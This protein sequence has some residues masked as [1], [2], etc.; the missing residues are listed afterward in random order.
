MEMFAE[1]VSVMLPEVSQGPSIPH[2]GLFQA[3]VHRCSIGVLSGRTQY[4]EFLAFLCK[5]CLQWFPLSSGIS[6]CLLY[7]FSVFAL[8]NNSALYLVGNWTFF[9]SNFVILLEIIVFSWGYCLCVH[10]MDLLFLLELVYILELWGSVCSIYLECR[11]PWVLI[12]STAHLLLLWL[13]RQY[14]SLT[15]FG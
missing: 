8:A 7:F 4:L 9:L 13:L 10:G 14:L 2:P 5:V 12:P 15:S 6:K 11:R 1:R 3:H